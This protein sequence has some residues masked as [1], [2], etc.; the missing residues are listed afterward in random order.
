MSSAAIV[1]VQA[2]RKLS[3]KYLAQKVGH[4]GSLG[5]ISMIQLPFCSSCV[6]LQYEPEMKFFHWV[7]PELC[8]LQKSE[9]PV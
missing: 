9:I 6:A 4:L 8:D 7:V 3:Q 2:I 1:F 5:L